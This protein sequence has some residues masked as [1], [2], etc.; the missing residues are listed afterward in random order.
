MV[1][2][3]T[4][5]NRGGRSARPGLQEK[6]VGFRSAV[7]VLILHSPAVYEGDAELLP[8][9]VG[10]VGVVLVQRG[11]Q[12]PAVLVHVGLVV[13]DPGHHVAAVGGVLGGVGQ[14]AVGGL[15]GI[16]IIR[17]NS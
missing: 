7:D 10:L 11:H 14:E 3:P 4:S 8:V 9:G 17:I 13:G 12:A 5:G 2:A 1:S 16:L 6:R 15:R